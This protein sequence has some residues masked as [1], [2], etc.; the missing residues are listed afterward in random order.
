MVEKENLSSAASALS[1]VKFLV[2]A[3]LACAAWC[4]SQLPAQAQGLRLGSESAFRYGDWPSYRGGGAV[5]T[6]FVEDLTLDNTACDDCRLTLQAG[7]RLEANPGI[8]EQEAASY[9]D[10][11][12]A[13]ARL[14]FAYLDWRPTG[15][16]QLRAGR[17]LTFDPDEFMSFDGVSLKLLTSRKLGIEASFGMAVRERWPLGFEAPAF[18]GLYFEDRPMTLLRTGLVA[19]GAGW[20][21]GRVFYRRAFDGQV[22]KDDV[23]TSVHLVPFPFL[24]AAFS[25]QYSMVVQRLEYVMADGAVPLG[26]FSATAGYA[27]RSP[28]FAGSSIFNYFNTSPYDEAHAGVSWSS[29]AWKEVSLRYRFRVLRS[30]GVYLGVLYPSGGRVIVGKAADLGG[31]A[32]DQGTDLAVR[33]RITGRVEG[34]IETS[35]AEGD[36]G[37]RT[38]GVVDLRYRAKP[39]LVLSCSGGGSKFADDSP[40]TYEGG[41]VVAGAGADFSVADHTTFSLALDETWVSFYGWNVYAT[42]GV[43]TGFELWK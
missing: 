38:T 25:A 6:V 37:R 1:A 13:A 12:R 33:R 35:Y 29:G 20:F 41:A 9:P 17:M 28:T 11:E 43:R 10:L 22:Q 7:L 26:P 32:F 4:A 16:I 14:H 27:R 36:G 21:S 39:W 40:R 2:V 23:G 24:S 42:A 19:E 34:G 31:Y 30:D 8:D 5:N 15:G 3:L 18:D